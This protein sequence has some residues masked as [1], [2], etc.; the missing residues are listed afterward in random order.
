[1]TRSKDL[2]AMSNGGRGSASV[3]VILMTIL[4]IFLQAQIVETDV[5][6][7]PREADN[8]TNPYSDNQEAMHRCIQNESAT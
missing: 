8:L 3:I 7:A 5:W 6:T 4:A 2:E 1:M